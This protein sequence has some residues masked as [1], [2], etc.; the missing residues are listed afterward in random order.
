MENPEVSVIVFIY[1]GGEGS[2]TAVPVAQE[3]LEYYFG[4]N[5]NGDGE[6]GTDQEAVQGEQVR[7]LD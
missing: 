7:R 4:L 2:V 1:N 3:I 6:N 5:E